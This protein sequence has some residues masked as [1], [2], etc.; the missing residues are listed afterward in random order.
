MTVHWFTIM[1]RKNM[2]TLDETWDQSYNHLSPSIIVVLF[3]NGIALKLRFILLD[4]TEAKWIVHTQT[5]RT[6]PVASPPP[7]PTSSSPTT[8]SP[9]SPLSASSTD[10]QNFKFWTWAEIRLKTLSR[11]LSREPTA[12]MKCEFCQKIKL[13]LLI[14]NYGLIFQSDSA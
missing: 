7:P 2:T 6:S 11:E 3:L 1:F 5:W 9:R 10:F 12:S 4:V 8:A 13:I 14:V